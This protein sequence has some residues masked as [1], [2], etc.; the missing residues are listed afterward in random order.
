VACGVCHAMCDR[1]AM[2]LLLL[3]RHSRSIARVTDR[4]SGA[5][6]ATPAIAHA[7]R[8]RDRHVHGPPVGASRDPRAM[9]T[10]VVATSTARL[11]G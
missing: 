2:L 5:R 8:Q 3:L 1:V 10:H 4:E 7:I 9:A 6:P 11:A